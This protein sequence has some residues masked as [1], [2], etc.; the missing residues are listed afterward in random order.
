MKRLLFILLLL[1]ITALAQLPDP[2]RY[3]LV[4]PDSINAA[5][6][7]PKVDPHF[8]FSTGIYSVGPTTGSYTLLAPSL[9]IQTS[10]K[11]QFRTKMYVLQ[12]SN[13]QDFLPWRRP[14]TAAAF[15]VGALYQAAPN[16]LLSADIYALEGSW[17]PLLLPIITPLPLEAYGFHAGLDYT[18]SSGNHIQFHL[19]VLR[20]RA[21]TLPPWVMGDPF[22]CYGPYGGYGCN[23]GFYI[24]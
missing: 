11:L 3:H 4:S 7:Y 1:P 23:G 12:G 6:D 9:N 22:G 17:S 15:S 14:T 10:P 16:L 21:G 18:L 19:N 2:A 8:S 24:P 20:D 5:L 13:H